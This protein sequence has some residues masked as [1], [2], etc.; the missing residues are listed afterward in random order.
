[1][2]EAPYILHI[3]YKD[4]TRSKLNLSGETNKE[5]QVNLKYWNSLSYISL[6]YLAWR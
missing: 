1:M 3:F 6:A 4:G 5:R 2:R